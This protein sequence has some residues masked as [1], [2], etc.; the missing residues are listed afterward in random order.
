MGVAE[1]IR[2][3]K[4]G[5]P[6]DVTLVAVSKFHPAEM[7]AEAYA[8]GQTCFGRSSHK[9]CRLSTLKYAGISS[10][11]C[12]PTRCASFCACVPP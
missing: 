3:I 5:L 1:N 7:I 2:E 4:L 10:A 9:K 11:I 6:E 12:R 8:A